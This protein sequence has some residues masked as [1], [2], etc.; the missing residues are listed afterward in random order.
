[1]FSSHGHVRRVSKY[2]ETDVEILVEDV[3]T[4]DDR[5]GTSHVLSTNS[6]RSGLLSNPFFRLSVAR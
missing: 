4:G 6:P 3:Q 5:L 1:M 2:S